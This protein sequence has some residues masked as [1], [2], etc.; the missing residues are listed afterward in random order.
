M[1]YLGTRGSRHLAGMM[2]MLPEGWKKGP[3]L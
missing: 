3:I 1:R 2:G